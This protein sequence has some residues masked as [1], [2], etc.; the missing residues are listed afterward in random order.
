MVEFC[1]CTHI[2]GGQ[3]KFMQT[4]GVF[5]SVRKG[6]YRLRPCK[7]NSPERQAQFRGMILR[8]FPAFSAVLVLILLRLQ[9]AD[10]CDVH[11]V[12]VNL[13]NL[14]VQTGCIHL[15]L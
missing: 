7:Q 14:D 4:P 13:L 15:R 12:L 10:Q 9:L 6:I 11:A 5:F 8:F 2:T 3:S 1:L